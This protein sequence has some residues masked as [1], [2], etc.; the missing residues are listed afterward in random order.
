MLACMFSYSL[1]SGQPE[2]Y[3]PRSPKGVKKSKFP[4]SKARSVQSLH[5]VLPRTPGVAILL[6]GEAFVRREQQ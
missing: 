3:E 5:V 6:S 1:S 2:L 4:S